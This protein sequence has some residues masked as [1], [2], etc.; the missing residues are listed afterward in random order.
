MK[1]FSSLL[2]KL[3]FTPS[4]NR[5]KSALKEYIANTPDPDRGYA[6]AAIT[7]DFK[8]KN[9]TASFYH[10]LIKDQV[11]YELF[12]MSY[13]YVGD[14][15]E[16]ISLIWPRRSVKKNQEEL[17]LHT[18]I[19][20][21]NETSKSKQKEII[22][23]I[24]NKSN[25]NER[26]SII[27]LTTGGFRIGVSA[28]L[29]KLAL[30]DYG[31]KEI[32]DIERIW[33]GLSY[34]YLN[35]FKW[36]ENKSLKPKIKFSDMFHP[37]ML[38]HPIN[39]EKDFSNLKP[40]DFVAELKWDGIRVQLVL[41]NENKKV[42]SR[43]GDEI[44]QSFPD[45][46]GNINGNAVLDG[47]L[48]V[49]RNFEALPFNFLQKRLNRKIPSKKIINEIPAFVKLYDILF[50]NGNDLR[51]LPLRKRRYILSNWLKLNPSKRLDIS[52]IIDFKDW[53]DLGQIKKESTEKFNQEGLMIK[54]K[55]SLYLSGR[56]RGLWFKW[57]KNPLFL[58]TILMYA[59]RGHGKRSSYYSD[60][61][62]GVL[63]NI[64]IVPIGKAYFGFTDKELKQLDNWVRK[65]TIKR[66]G[67]VR[68]VKKELVLEIAFDSINESKRHK[69]GLALRFPRIHR[70]RWDKPTN[71]TDHLQDI[72][73]NYLN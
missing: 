73:K 33:H 50:E 23:D 15:A 56:P 32:E 18:F 19:K 71:E 53:N 10:Q 60:F 8:V 3:L 58:D 69:S 48:L 46:A 31:N 2:E 54:S 26:W 14:L 64:E 12:K 43:T 6:L 57:K 67:P 17:S 30:A 29:V 22:F 52:K 70:I 65:N 61:T 59:Q 72:K 34:P 11:D 63:N 9:I 24:M 35:L 41:D 39:E 7:G 38:A 5:K 68:E 4:R 1:T 45:I 51:D 25:A 47:E 21:I 66:F 28:K 16:T 13:D 55:N 62:F 27:K 36:L 49:G 40:R 44:S 20:L 42:Y 37:M